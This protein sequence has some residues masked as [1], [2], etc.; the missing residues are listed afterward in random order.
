MEINTRSLVRSDFHVLAST[1]EGFKFHDRSSNVSI[2]RTVSLGLVESEKLIK[3]ITLLTSVEPSE[4]MRC[5][6]PRYAAECH[7]ENGASVRISFCFR[8]KNIIVS[9]TELRGTMGFDP[10]NPPGRN[11][12]AFLRATSGIVLDTKSI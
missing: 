4:Q 8:C 11:L 10:T 9:S 3:L 12:M 2:E 6:E 7:Y 5:H 1:D